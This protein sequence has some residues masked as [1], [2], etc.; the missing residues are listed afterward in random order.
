M[1]LPP[2]PPER[3]IQHIASGFPVEALREELQ[4]ADVWNRNTLRTQAQ[5]TPH[6]TSSDI[7]VRFKAWDEVLAD[8]AHC[9]DE[10]ESVWYPV[11]ME[12]PAVIPLIEAVMELSGA[13][14]LGGVLITK[15]PPGG[16]IE[17]HIDRGWHAEVHRKFAV[18]IAGNEHQAFCFENAVLRPVSGEVY[19]FRN[20]ESHWV[21]NESSSDRITLIVCVR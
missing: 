18:Q 5:A 12:I 6:K 13:D 9:C 20:Q 11:L 1:R 17:P 21:T 2:L 15:V 10:H 4:C 7:W 3:P 14:T 19:E 16:R 8:P